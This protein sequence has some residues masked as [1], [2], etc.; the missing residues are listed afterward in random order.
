MST[1]QDPA[2]GTRSP[3]K[4][5]GWFPN[6][7]LLGPLLALSG[8]ELSAGPADWPQWGGPRRNFT[9]DGVGLAE[10]WPEGGPRRL[11]RRELGEGYSGIAVEDGRL[12]TMYRES[13][14]RTGGVDREV[15]VALD[16]DS[17]ATLWEYRYAAA[18]LPG[19]ALEHG[20][21][22]HV[23][24]LVDES[25]V[26]T[27]GIRAHLH[28]LDKATGRVVWER[29]LMEEFGAPVQRRGHASSPIAYGDTIIL[30]VGGP[31]QAL[32]AFRGS[33]GSV[34]WKSGDMT[35]S[36][37]S[38]LLIDV[39]GQDQLVA[40]M[41]REI[42]GVDPAGGE[43]LWRQTHVAQYGLNISMPVWG[44]GNLLFCSSAYGGGSRLLRL[45][46]SAGGTEARELWHTNRM[47][48]H[49]G[50]AIRMG[51]RVIGS[52]GDFGPAFLAAVDLENGEVVWQD[53]GFGKANLIHA[54]DRLILLDEDGE[55]AL[56]EVTPTGPRVVSRAKVLEHNAW[57]APS[58]VGSR[59]YLRDRQQIMALDLGAD[60]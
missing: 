58:L 13:A 54:G 15:V 7:F 30:P 12:Y 50:N 10:S 28:C 60:R 16:A 21:G 24:P 35:V 27:I 18:P 45:S 53:R 40:F 2:H 34:A 26:F 48:I 4:G 20:P 32:M 55:L 33:D 17:G 25:Y 14:G 3:R 8:S 31:G 39:D 41:A 23:T 36:P 51:D 57:T 52:S 11:W 19:M 1:R 22:P 47:R 43:V 59:L 42:V 56:V 44:E 29:D 38:P 6:L 46:R 5:S 9:V 49:I 37:S